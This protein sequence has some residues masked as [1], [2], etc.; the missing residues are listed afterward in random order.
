MFNSI[1]TK[2]GP[3]ATEFKFDRCFSDQSRSPCRRCPNNC[4]QHQECSLRFSHAE[5]ELSKYV[6][7]SV[8]TACITEEKVTANEIVLRLLCRISLGFSENRH[9]LEISA[10]D[11]AYVLENFLPKAEHRPTS[12]QYPNRAIS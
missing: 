7:S 10:Y 5:N 11:S 8:I 3:V 4:M 9:V 1:A 12:V 6:D 2:N